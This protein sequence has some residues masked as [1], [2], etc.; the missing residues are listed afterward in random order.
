[1]GADVLVVAPKRDQL[2]F[3][4]SIL[5]LLKTVS[6]AEN[7]SLGFQHDVLILLASA[8]FVEGEPIPSQLTDFND[9]GLSNAISSLVVTDPL[10]NILDVDTEDGRSVLTVLA[11]AEDTDPFNVE[12]CY[13]QGI[14]KTMGNDIQQDNDLGI[15]KA[16]IDIFSEFQ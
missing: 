15:G 13:L 12:L 9:K 10:C 7:N 16:L 3:S 4:G 14:S 2:H 8:Q 11:N 5:K 1:M 6:E